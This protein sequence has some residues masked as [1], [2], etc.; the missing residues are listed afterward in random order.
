[1]SYKDTNHKKIHGSQVCKSQL[2]TKFLTHVTS[3]NQFDVQTKFIM[4]KNLWN[5][6]KKRSWTNPTQGTKF[7]KL[8]RI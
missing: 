7:H 5:G 3:N 1:M 8:N 4:N 6:I 2:T